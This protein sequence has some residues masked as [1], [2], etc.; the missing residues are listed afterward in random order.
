MPELPEVETVRRGLTGLVKGA[1]IEAVALP[2]PKVLLSN[3]AAFQEGL[4]GARIEAIDRRGKYLLFRLSNAQTI[5]SH[6]RMEGQ[7]SVEPVGAAP[8][9]QT[10]VIFTLADGRDLMYNDTRRFGR[11]QLVATGTENEVVPGLAAMGPEPTEDELTL[12]YLRT[13]LQ[14]SHR[15][16]KPFLLDQSKIAGLGNIYTDEVLW[17]TKIHPETLTDQVTASQVAD[18]RTNIIEEMKR[19]IKNH[20]TT[21]HS[22]SN[23]Y[24]EVGKFQN[25]LD[26]YGRAGLPCKRCQTTLE[27]MKVAQRGTTYC[28]YCQ[29]KVASK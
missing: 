17:Q 6:L 20:G 5:V 1:E 16:I 23:V 13:I 14:Q 24:G 29:V 12:P 11:M 19:A 26:V 10:E 28:P 3:P 2:Y 21:V 27:K 9:K 15:R 18:L 8:H 25:Q 7:Y 4:Q 22:F